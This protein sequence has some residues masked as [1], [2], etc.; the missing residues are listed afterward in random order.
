MHRDYKI[1]PRSYKKQVN[2]EASLIQNL[3]IMVFTDYIKSLPNQQQ[4]TIKKL[5]EITYSSPMSVYRWVNGHS[6]PPLIKQKVIAD[7][8]GM[9]VE[10]LFPN[11]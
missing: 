11:K 1:T 10:E 6:V 4:D 3:S 8:L 9:S 7:Y 5:A 2:S